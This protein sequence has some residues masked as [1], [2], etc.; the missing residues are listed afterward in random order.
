MATDRRTNFMAVAN[1]TSANEES[2]C[3]TARRV[4]L[5]CKEM[6]VSRLMNSR[7]GTRFLNTGSHH[8]ME[9]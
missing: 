4:S 9:V 3:R 7:R 5:T 2:V 1:N 8:S 6:I